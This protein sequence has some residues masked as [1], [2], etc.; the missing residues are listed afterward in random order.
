MTLLPGPDAF[1]LLGAGVLEGRLEPL[2]YRFAIIEPAQGGSGGTFAKAAFR[3]GDRAIEL[4]ARHD[5]LGGVE[6]RLGSDAFSHQDHM[7]A[8]GLEKAAEW[9]GFDDGDPLGGFRRL[10][11]DLRH[12][13]DFLTGDAAAVLAM[14]QA[15]P[16]KPTGFRALSSRPAD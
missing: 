1:L 3:R 4:W 12:C 13:D 9:P 14:V 7:R 5:R 15:L 8:L 2:G 6:Y 16:P 11:S 10:L